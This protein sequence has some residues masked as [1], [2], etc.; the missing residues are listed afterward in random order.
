MYL[1][2]NSENLE[3]SEGSLTLAL[4]VAVVVSA[5]RGV[6]VLPF[7]AVA[8]Q[9]VARQPATASEVAIV[10][11]ACCAPHV[12]DFIPS[13]RNTGLRTAPTACRGWRNAR[14]LSS[15]P[16]SSDG[17]RCA[18]QCW[19]RTS[20]SGATM[21]YRCCATGAY[22]WHTISLSIAD[23]GRHNFVSARYDQARHLVAF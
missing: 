10:G 8:S 16:P 1:G 14:L 3:N 11:R 21:C 19:R 9:S 4:P 18:A 22:L 7:S 23:S 15:A 13:R 5:W 17:C 2:T 12:A 20:S 6:G